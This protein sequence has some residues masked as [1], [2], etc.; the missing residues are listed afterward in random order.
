MSPGNDSKTLRRMFSF[1]AKLL[2]QK[3]SF[4]EPCDKGFISLAENSKSNLDVSPS[5]TVNSDKTD[6]V[7][8]QNEVRNNCL[9]IRIRCSN[10]LHLVSTQRSNK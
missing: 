1:E 4:I 9:L 10:R 6:S 3:G 5:K 8:H 2:G 7:V